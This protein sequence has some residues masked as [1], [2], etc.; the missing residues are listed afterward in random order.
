MGA[1]AGLESNTPCDD[2]TVHYVQKGSTTL[3]ECPVMQNVEV[4]LMSWDFYP[5]D[6]SDPLMNVISS[7]RFRSETNRLIMSDIQPQD[8]GMYVCR[9]VEEGMPERTVVGGC[10]IVHGTISSL[11]NS[12]VFVTAYEG[13]P[14]VL[15]T[16]VKIENWGPCKVL[17]T[18]T[19]VRLRH[20]GSE[21]VLMCEDLPCPALDGSVKYN[22]MTLGN[23]TLAP[24]RVMSGAYTFAVVQRCPDEVQ[25]MTYDV[26]LAVMTQ[27]AAP[28]GPTEAPTEPT[29]CTT[30]GT[31]ATTTATEG[32]SNKIP[33]S[34]MSFTLGIGISLFMMH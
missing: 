12:S 27:T 2:S 16:E 19:Q 29:N 14:F 33:L 23:T 22:F 18:L 3:L 24:S 8:E 25:K 11:D 30:D 15:N 34:M 32:S 4:M 28:S 13:E 17:P 7:P 31:N 1:E 10:V 21:V 9:V 6:G 5:S 26:A 20:E